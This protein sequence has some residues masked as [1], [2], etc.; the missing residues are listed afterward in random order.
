MKRVASAE[1]L[2]RG[3]HGKKQD[4]LLGRRSAFPVDLRPASWSQLRYSP[5]FYNAERGKTVS[6]NF[7]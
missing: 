4:Q 6:P 2:V 3:P 1:Y 7:V 5:V